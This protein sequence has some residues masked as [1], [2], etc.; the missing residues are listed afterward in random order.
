MGERDTPLSPGEEYDG[1]DRGDEGDELAETY[2]GRAAW[3]FSLTR[4]EKVRRGGFSALL[5]AAVAFVVLGGPGALFTGLSGAMRTTSAPWSALRQTAANIQ[6]PARPTLPLA[7]VRLPPGT[8]RT[9]SLRVSPLNT[10]TGGANACWISSDAQARGGGIGAL[11]FATLKSTTGQ[12]VAHPPPARNANSC[13]IASDTTDPNRVLF[14]LWQTEAAAANCGL[15]ALYVSPDGGLTW[16]AARWPEPNA[17]ACLY[18]LSTVQHQIYALADAPLLSASQPHGNA[19]A[20]FIMSANDGKSWRPM[21][22]G[23]VDMSNF[24]IVGV[25]PGGHVLAQATTEASGQ[26]GA[27]FETDNNGATWR[28]LGDLPGRAVEVYASSDPRDTAHGGFGRLYLIGRQGSSGGG[29][30]ASQPYIATAYAGS[31]WTPLPAPP[32]NAPA[33]SVNTAIITSDVGPDDSLVVTLATALASN[34]SPA[35]SPALWA[36]DPTTSGWTRQPYDIPLNSASQGHSWANGHM[37]TWLLITSS[38]A[39]QVAEIQTYVLPVA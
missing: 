13:Y 16:H 2:E 20:H 6:P 18:A 17:S 8:A 34:G 9:S 28:S 1:H 14:A 32:E 22:N 35:A 5:I 11:H 19:P 10:A 4:R 31:Q 15:P 24:Y 12:W 26:P 33:G 29:N 38:G 37:L 25:R 7:Q 23:F 27:L 3:A 36:W 30:G 21:D 39:A